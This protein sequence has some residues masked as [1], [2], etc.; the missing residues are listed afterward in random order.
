[1]AKLC[2]VRILVV[3]NF[4]MNWSS[5]KRMSM[6]GKF[7]IVCCSLNLCSSWGDL[8]NFPVFQSLYSVNLLPLLTWFIFYVC[9]SI[10]RTFVLLLEMIQIR[11]WVL[12][13]VIAN[14]SNGYWEYWT[15]D[16]HLFVIVNSVNYITSEY[17]EFVFNSF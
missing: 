4:L 3:I 17:I 9:L 15:V 8:C 13:Y 2:K 6:L 5:D 10:C 7:F 12:K 14:I 1:M 11:D 16:F